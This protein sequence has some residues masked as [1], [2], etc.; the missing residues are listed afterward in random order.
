MV[1]QRPDPVID[2]IHTQSTLTQQPDDDLRHAMSGGASDLR[3]TISGADGLRH[4]M[5]GADD[6]RHTMTG[7]VQHIKKAS[8]VIIRTIPEVTPTGTYSSLHSDQEVLPREPVSAR[9]LPST[10]SLESPVSVGVWCSVCVL[11]VMCACLC[12]CV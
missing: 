12:G 9:I 6:L 4:T 7:G 10:R 1:V 8:P 2:P 11:C 5:G 3:H